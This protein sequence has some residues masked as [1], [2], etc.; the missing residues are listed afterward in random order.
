MKCVSNS[1]LALIAISVALSGCASLSAATGSSKAKPDEFRVLTKA[2]LEIPPEYNLVPPR[3]GERRPQ[4]LEASQAARIAMLGGD[5]VGGASVGEQVLVAKARGDLSDS[6]IRARLDSETNGQVTKSNSFAD[7]IL[8]WRGGDTYIEGGTMLDADAE[9]EI[10]RRKESAEKATGG[11]KV[12]I[13]K[14][15]RGIKLPGL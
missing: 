14:K 4:D 2:P 5:G 1:V 3:P 10:L 15:G 9:A 13:R 11:G 12:V 6:S 7:R 8:F